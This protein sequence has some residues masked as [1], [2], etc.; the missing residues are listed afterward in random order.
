LSR[1]ADFEIVADAGS[2]DEAISIAADVE[3][4]VIM[5]DLSMPDGISGIQA[6]RT[7]VAARPET[8]VVIVSTF[9]EPH[10]VA[11]AFDAGARGYFLKTAK[12]DELISGV[13]SIL[14]GTAS[15][16]PA[17]AG[18]LNGATPSRLPADLTRRE[19]EVLELIL[20]GHTN[21]QIANALGISEKTV[22]THCGN[23]FQRLGVRDRTQAAVWAER[24]LTRAR[25]RRH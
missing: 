16:S 5:M 25:N 14:N 9:Q 6:T 21:R 12:P 18:R 2:G 8:I 20:D 13:R 23:L 7:I 10:D 15:L 22:K 11:A 24:H 19:L 4:D 17:V 3:P 1:E